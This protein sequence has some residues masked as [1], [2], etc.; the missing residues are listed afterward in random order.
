MADVGRLRWIL[1]ADTRQFD[2]AMR[3]TAD[4]IRRLAGV[5]ATAFSAQRIAGF[6][7]GLLSTVDSMSKLARAA[8][9]TVEQ[10]QLLRHAGD[11]AGVSQD[12]LDDALLRFNKRLGEAQMGFGPLLRMMARYDQTAAVRLLS[13]TS[14]LQALGQMSRIIQQAPTPAA[15]AALTSGA[16]GTGNLRMV[17]LMRG[18]PRG[19]AT[20]M[21]S[22]LQNMA[23]LSS[24]AARTFEELQDTVTRVQSNISSTT[25]NAT[26]QI[27]TSITGLVQRIDRFLLD[28]RQQTL[29]ER[30][31]TAVGAAFNFILPGFSRTTR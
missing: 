11:L 27:V 15:A 29:G 1:T 8:G 3:R 16:F 31:A 25:L 22:G 17:N 21:E 14:S 2:A 7:S 18:G 23:L 19:L 12:R 9:V 30:A 20:A 4:G 5:A 24:D 6:S 13:S 26:A 10:L 28:L